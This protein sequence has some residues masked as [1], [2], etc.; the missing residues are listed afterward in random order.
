MD[1]VGP[2]IEPEE[3]K[4]AIRVKRRAILCGWMRALSPF[5][6]SRHT[7]R[8]GGDNI[9]AKPAEEKKS[10]DSNAFLRDSLAGDILS[11]DTDNVMPSESALSYVS[12]PSLTEIGG[13]H[14]H[15][16]EQPHLP[17]VLPTQNLSSPSVNRADPRTPPIGHQRRRKAKNIMYLGLAFLKSSLNPGS[18]SI[19]VSLPIALIPPLK[20]LFIKVPS[21]N[22]PSAPDGLPPLAFFFDT[23]TFIG[24]ASVPL[25]LICLGSALARMNVPRNKEGW[26]MLPI[27]AITGI[28]VGRI[29]I[30][31]VVGVL[32]VQG[33]VK[34]GVIP[35]TDKVLQFVCMYAI[36]YQPDF[37]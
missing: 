29:I 28:A 35:R 10:E 37:S 32:L 25:G 27:G 23:T 36:S 33:L 21:V 4:V 9:E 30:M 15:F 17:F 7:S 18:L 26:R 31:P 14:H 16:R 6:R 13:Q 2:D 1:Y 8:S 5:F 3:V 34:G 12:A 24:A 20:A 22:M 19:L 11:A